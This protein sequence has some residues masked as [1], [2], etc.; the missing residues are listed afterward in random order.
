MAKETIKQVN[1][2]DKRDVPDV[3][4]VEEVTYDEQHGE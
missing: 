3:A 2:Q 1:E 4:P